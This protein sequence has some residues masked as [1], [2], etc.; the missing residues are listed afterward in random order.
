MELIMDDSSLE[1][2]RSK[3]EAT[4]RSWSETCGLAPEGVTGKLD[5]AMFNWMS[6]LTDS[7]DIWIANSLLDHR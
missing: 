5:A 1:Q 4:I 6:D 2:I 7:L 3:T